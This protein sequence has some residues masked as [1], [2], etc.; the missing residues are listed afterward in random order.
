MGSILSAKVAYIKLI[1]VAICCMCGSEKVTYSDNS[2]TIL[3]LDCQMSIMGGKFNS[4][5][6]G[7][8]NSGNSSN[9]SRQQRRRIPAKTGG[10][11][12]NT[13]QYPNVDRAFI[14]ISSFAE[15]LDD[16]ERPYCVN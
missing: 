16:W 10:S 5:F 2:M 14:E 13:W 1:H 7:T 3:N 11:S 15:L 4:F 8:G 6:G 9:P 12:E